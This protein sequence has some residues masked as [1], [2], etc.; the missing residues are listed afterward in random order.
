MRKRIR[1]SV[2][3]HKLIKLS[4]TDNKNCMFCGK[5]ES[6]EMLYGLLY[7][8]DN[9]VVHLYCIV[10][11]FPKNCIFLLHIDKYCYKNSYF[12]LL[13]EKSAQNGRDHEGVCGFLLKDITAEL[14]RASKVVS[15]FYICL[16]SELIN[17]QSYKNLDWK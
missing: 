17:Y 9:V 5:N 8:L 16:K 3:P 12:Q 13:S 10:S 15:I 6:S 7:Q 2:R 11:A 1:N 14:K 4:L